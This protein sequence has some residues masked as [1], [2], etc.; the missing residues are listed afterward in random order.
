MTRACKEIGGINLAQGICDLPTHKL[1]QQG[2]IEAIR[3]HRSIYS[4]HEGIPELREAIAKKMADYNRIICDPASEIV[5]TV[6][7]TGAFVLALLALLD[8]DDEVVLFEPFY[9]Y[10]RNA[11]LAFRGRPVSVLLR[12]PG[13]QIDVEELHKAFS[14]RT[15]AIVVCSPSN[16]SGKV[17]KRD[18]LSAIARVCIENDVIAVTDEIYE[19]IVYDGAEHVSLATLPGMRERTVTISGFSKTFSITGWRLGYAVA[20]AE[21]A[22]TI[23]VLNDLLYVCAPTPLQHGAAR[24][25]EVGPEYYTALAHS[26]ARKRKLMAEALR[27]A[28]FIPIV[29]Q[30]AYY[31]LADA[32][33]LG[34]GPSREVAGWLLA[35]AGVASVPGSAFY[36]GTDGENLL[37]FCFAKDDEVLIEAGRR[38]ASVSRRND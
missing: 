2:A 17:F 6:G 12:G 30:G 38:M 26:Y 8:P 4:L 35:E 3:E 13:F 24:G 19:Y 27:G 21:M 32:S 16:P 31:T 18:E 36:T 20:P 1:A 11:I 28:G 14:P 5:V 34:R 23:G 22:Q 7:A 25:M 15:K 33:P 29:P 10:H 9:S 37:R